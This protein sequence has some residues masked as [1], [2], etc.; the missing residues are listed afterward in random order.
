MTALGLV[1]P[2]SDSVTLRDTVAYVISRAV[3]SQDDGRPAVHFIYP[4]SGRGP[5]G[6]PTEEAREFLERIEVWAEEDLGEAA[7]DV[8]IET[9]IVGRSE[10][11]FNPSDY[12]AAFGR[13][14]DEHG[15]E[16]VVLDPEFNPVGTMP[17]LPPLERELERAGLAVETAPVERTTQRGPL[18]RRAGIGQFVV[19][20]GW[21]FGF[22][23]LI[24]G[25]LS[26]F[27]LATGALSGL[28]VAALL[29]RVSLRGIANPR[30]TIG[31]FARLAMYVPMLL[32][33]IAKANVEIAAVV[34]HP[35]LPIDPE[36][37]EF[38]AAV[39]SE[40][41]VATLANSITLTPGTLTVDVEQRHFTV[42]TL[43]TDARMSLLDGRLERGV[44]AVFYGRSA[45]NIQTPAE[46]GAVG[47]TEDAAGETET[48]NAVEEIEAEGRDRA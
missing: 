28:V 29:W 17:L 42:H 4:I 27:D 9:G 32:W 38:D 26:A 5:D 37:V 22:Y 30:R 31:R 8:T 15:L 47:E 7:G 16:T 48:E 14:A 39:W 19:L 10:Y 46:R 36:V 2:V 1:V 23:L 21:A 6:N 44:R 3:E 35:D 13:Y 25:S 12:T 18:R 41:P 11:L 33:M 20:F 24:G 45:A 43:T 34:L 40:L